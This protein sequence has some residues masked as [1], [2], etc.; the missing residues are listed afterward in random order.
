MKEVLAVENAHFLADHHVA[1]ADGA[2]VIAPLDQLRVLGE[3]RGGER[4][5]H[6]LRGSLRRMSGWVGEC[7][8][9]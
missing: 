1:E 2:G 9:V 5:D 8:R 4:L 7:E 6:L 3:R